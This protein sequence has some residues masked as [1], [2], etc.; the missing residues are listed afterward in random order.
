MSDSN[1]RIMLVDDDRFEQ[2]LQVRR[3]DFVHQMRRQVS[4]VQPHS[5]AVVA[6]LFRNADGVLT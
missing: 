4:I 2:W 5:Q 1:D 6:R 3:A